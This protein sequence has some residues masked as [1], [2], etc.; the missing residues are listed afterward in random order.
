MDYTCASTM[1]Q[2]SSGDIIGWNVKIALVHVAEFSFFLAVLPFC[3]TAK[4]CYVITDG[5]VLTH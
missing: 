3:L 1:V 5:F 4:K 2:F